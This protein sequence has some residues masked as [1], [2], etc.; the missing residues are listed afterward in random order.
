MRNTVGSDVLYGWVLIGLFC[1]SRADA[2][3]FLRDAPRDWIP[4][5]AILAT[6][7]ALRDS[8]GRILAV[9]VLP[10][11]EADRWLF[12]GEV[13]TATLQRLLWHG[14]PVLW[15]LIPL[16]VYLSH[17]IATP[18][19]AAVLWKVAR[20]RFVWFRRR[21]IALSFAGLITYALYPAAPPWLAA[22]EG[23][24]A[25]VT[26][27]VP[28]FAELLP[29]HG[30]GGL[31]TTGAGYGNSV[32]AV[33]S[34]HAAFSLLIAL[35]LWPGVPRRW[36]PLL[37]AYPLAMAFSVV[38]CAEHYV[39]DVLL[40]WLYTGGVLLA[41]R[42]ASRLREGRPARRAPALADSLT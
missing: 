20:R 29:I 35:T 4:F 10:Q 32:A 39:C 17:F 1:C 15:D 31:L 9:H 3:G 40:G 38:F 41:F 36:R 5:I 23:A 28:R 42:V 21:V 37:L 27:L 7:S 8:A 14:H 22:R 2:R 12:G 33:P 13:P 24:I 6:Y 18:L 26:R 34:L 11:A 16:A 30:L 19:L 25:P